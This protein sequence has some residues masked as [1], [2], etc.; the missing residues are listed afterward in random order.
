MEHQGAIKEMEKGI[1]R[2]RKELDEAKSGTKT[3]QN[4]S[5]ICGNA[6]KIDI[7]GNK[8]TIKHAEK[9]A[10]KDFRDEIADA[11]C[12]CTSRE[13]VIRN[14]KDDEDIGNK[15]NYINRLLRHEVIHAYMFECGLG[16]EIPHP[17]TGHDEAMIDW[18]AR[19]APRIMQTFIE[20]DIAE[21]NWY[22]NNK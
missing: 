1:T 19:M 14:I 22:W 7:L 9:E 10:V 2:L 17:Q 20:L 4:E 16:A 13:I 11:F 12:D 15:Q 6:M 3:S 21:L 18:F 5:L 8:Y